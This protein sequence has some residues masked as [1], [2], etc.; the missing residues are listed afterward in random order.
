[1]SITKPPILDDTGRDI[2]GKLMDIGDALR[3]QNARGGAR[4][5]G[6]HIDGSESD[7]DEMVTYLEDA[8]GATPA[9]MDYATDKFEYGSWKGAFFMP[10]PCMVKFDGTV[11]Y[12]LDASN[13]GLKE[14]G[15][16]SDIADATYEGNAMMEWPKI[17]IKIVPDADD[18]ASGSVYICDRKLDSGFHAYS[19]INNQ[20][21][22][23]NHFYTPIYQGSLDAN[24]KLRSLSGKTLMQSKT[25]A[26]EL[27]AARALNEG[28]DVLWNTETLS[29]RLTITFLLILMAKSVDT[30]T[31]YG[32]GRQGQE[33]AASSLLASGTMNT[34]GLF[35]GDDTNTAGVKV[36]GI[37]NFWGNQWHRVLGYICDHGAQ[38]V[39]MT[40][41]RQDGSTADDYNFTGGGYIS[42]GVSVANG[43]G[44]LDACVF[45]AMGMFMKHYGA[46]GAS[47]S[48]YYAD[49]AYVNTSVVAVAR[50]GGGAGYGA[51]Y[52][53]AL[54]C[55]LYD[56]ASGAHWTLG[57]APSFK[58]L[59]SS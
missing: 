30:Q 13:Y 2:V 22:E 15:T 51:G 21:V 35:W 27:A 44:Y 52:P 34:K 46:E 43:N 57:A 18:N 50:F 49:Y 56:D 45:N 28:D 29:D 11:D 19:N 12:Y 38:K 32:N 59:A 31:A 9:H 20:G 47:S 4:L 10:K 1:M 58:P 6:F 37:E 55:S 48:T 16:A 41:G 42:L 25:A 7:P 5:Y 3:Y 33:S 24:D 8:I 36:F 23:V 54:S 53:G 17:W 14:D 39:K 40:A 26:E